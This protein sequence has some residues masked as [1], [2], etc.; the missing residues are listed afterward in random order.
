MKNTGLDCCPACDTS[1]PQLLLD[2]SPLGCW[3]SVSEQRKANDCSCS[4]GTLLY[5]SRGTDP[6]P[7]EGMGSTKPTRT[8]LPGPRNLLCFKWEKTPMHVVCLRADG[9]THWCQVNLLKKPH[10]L[11]L[12]FGELLLKLVA[13][14]LANTVTTPSVPVHSQQG[15]IWEFLSGSPLA[16]A[17][18][19]KHQHTT[20]HCF[21]LTPYPELL[22]GISATTPQI[23]YRFLKYLA[24]TLNINFIFYF[25]LCLHYYSLYYNVSFN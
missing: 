22:L 2:H 1:S 18:G 10:H 13:M 19:V 24:F 16:M 11:L 6:E 7:Q 25:L 20:R 23:G 9:H 8:P 3:S 14:C 12:P 15:F 5:R 17:Q 21:L 4:E